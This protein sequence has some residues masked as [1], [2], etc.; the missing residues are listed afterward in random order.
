MK[1]LGL[2]AITFVMLFAMTAQSFAADLP[3]DLPTC[4]A[5]NLEITD[6]DSF[7]SLEGMSDY[8]TIY[9]ALKEKYKTTAFDVSNNIFGVKFKADEE[10]I[11]NQN[12][13][14]DYLVDFEVVADED[15]SVILVGYYETYGKAVALGTFDFQKGV[16]QRIMQLAETESWKQIPYSLVV[17]AVK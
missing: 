8:Q 11:T 16:P 5:T 12:P 14:F 3:S 15:I 4:T 13:Y 1:K 2:I 17:N 6:F 7:F 9:N 10:S